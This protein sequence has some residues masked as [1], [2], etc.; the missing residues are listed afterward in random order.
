[1]FLLSKPSYL[2]G[3]SLYPKEPC[4]FANIV[5]DLKILKL[6]SRRSEHPVIMELCR[7]ERVLLK[8]MGFRSGAAF[9][10]SE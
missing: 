2:C 4:V 5:N 1:M 10:G 3:L 7:L 6:D 8:K 9:S